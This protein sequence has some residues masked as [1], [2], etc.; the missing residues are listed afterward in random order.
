MPGTA[1][2]IKNTDMSVTKFQILYV[3]NKAY[4]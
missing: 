1:I 2:N 3:G 4:C